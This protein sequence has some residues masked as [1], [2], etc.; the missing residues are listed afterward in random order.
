MPQ[1]V[2]FLVF[3]GILPLIALS[4]CLLESGSPKRLELVVA[5]LA[6]KEGGSGFGRDSRNCRYVGGC[7]VEGWG[8]SLALAAEVGAVLDVGPSL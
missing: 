4:S 8:C 1:L 7:T 2:D 5:S 3:F 6:A